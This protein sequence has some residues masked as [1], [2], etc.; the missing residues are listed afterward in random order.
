MQNLSLFPPWFPIPSGLNFTGYNSQTTLFTFSSKEWGTQNQATQY[1]MS[2]ITYQEL[3]IICLASLTPQLHYPP[4]Y[5]NF[6]PDLYSTG[7][8]PNELTNPDLWT[9][10]GGGNFELQP[11]KGNNTRV[12]V[13]SQLSSPFI[14]WISGGSTLYEVV[15]YSKQLNLWNIKKRQNQ[16]RVQRKPIDLYAYR[17]RFV[18]GLSVSGLTNAEIQIIMGWTNSAMVDQYVDAVISID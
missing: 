12:L 13:E 3:K 2:V 18:K 14:E 6:L 10:I 15:T 9:P 1:I 8:R 11:L 7:C 16:L 5:N 4:V 17:Y